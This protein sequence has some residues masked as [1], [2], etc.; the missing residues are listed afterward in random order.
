MSFGRV[1]LQ[2]F[3]PWRLGLNV[4]PMPRLI[5]CHIDPP[6]LTKSCYPYNKLIE[7]WQV[8]SEL[9][10]W[11]DTVQ[12]KSNRIVFDQSVMQDIGRFI[13]IGLP[14][15]GLSA[16][17]LSGQF[18]IQELEPHCHELT[19]KHLTDTVALIDHFTSGLFNNIDLENEDDVNDIR[20]LLII[21][22]NDV[23]WYGRIFEWEDYLLPMFKGITDRTAM[24]GK[25][26]Q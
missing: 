9:C 21:S 3:R 24:T 6:I 17:I 16:R 15:G 2:Q 1:A 23:F 19:R 20:K 5:T 18:T 26:F 22:G 25:R 10:V 8:K 4:I 11:V 12:L 14:P 7:N 13:L